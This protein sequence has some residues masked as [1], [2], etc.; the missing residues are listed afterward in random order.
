MA[1]KSATGSG[2]LVALAL[3][4]FYATGNVKFRRKM[5]SLLPKRFLRVRRETLQAVKKFDVGVP[6]HH[7]S[8]RNII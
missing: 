8:I 3:F 4:D 5:A 6:H 1:Q 2:W 7:S